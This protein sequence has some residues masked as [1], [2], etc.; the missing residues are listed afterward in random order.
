VL[1]AWMG[2]RSISRWIRPNRHETSPQKLDGWMDG[3]ALGTS[4]RLTHGP[5][6]HGR[7]ALLL[8]ARS[9][10]PIARSHARTRGQQRT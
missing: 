7:F 2:R 1:V 10:P 6:I 3:P 4:H 5:A 9:L 8:T